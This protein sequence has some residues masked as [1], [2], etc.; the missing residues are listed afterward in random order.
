MFGNTKVTTSKEKQCL[1]LAL[2]WVVLDSLGLVLGIP[3][4]ILEPSTTLLSPMCS[5]CSL[6]SS[7]F[8][9]PSEL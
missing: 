3:G 1:G 6:L 5:S 8:P 4:A 7:L 9:W 2:F